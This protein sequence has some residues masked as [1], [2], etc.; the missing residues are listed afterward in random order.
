[1]GGFSFH[2]SSE[3]G[4]GVNL[5]DCSSVCLCVCEHVS[6]HPDRSVVKGGKE[7]ILANGHLMA[8]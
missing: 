6:L 4:Q 2:P 7:L 5:P 3:V 8:L 1:M